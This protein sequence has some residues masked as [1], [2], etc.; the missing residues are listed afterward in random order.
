RQDVDLRY[1]VRRA[2]GGGA[3][4]GAAT[5]RPRQ[6]FEV[7]G[8]PGGGHRLEPE[9]D[10]EDL[11]QVVLWRDASAAT[12]GTRAGGGAAG[13][14]RTPAAATAVAAIAVAAAPVTSECCWRRSW[15]SAWRSPRAVETVDSALAYVPS[16]MRPD[17]TD[18]ICAGSETAA[19]FSSAS[20][21]LARAL[22]SPS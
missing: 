11:L 20:R 12:G 10:L 19:A 9:G 17:T 7:F 4:A 13:A 1:P 5:N 3:R 14:V 22:E 2:S 16:S 6:R 15:L 8:R 21:S 18:S